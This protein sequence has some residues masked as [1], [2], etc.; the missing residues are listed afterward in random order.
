MN[1]IGSF[2]KTS[3]TY[4]SFENTGGCSLRSSTAIWSM[5]EPV[6]DIAPWSAASTVS[7]Y[8]SLSSLSMVLFRNTSPVVELI[9]NFPSS[10]PAP[11]LYLSTALKSKSLSM[12]ITLVMDVPGRA[13]SGMSA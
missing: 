10:L 8:V 1:P 12:A 11:M 7:M 9:R 4:S 6:S 13:S 3:A 5:A 2:S